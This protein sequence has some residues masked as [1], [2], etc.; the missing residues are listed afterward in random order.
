[1]KT[2]RSPQRLEQNGTPR[3][4]FAIHHGDCLDVLGKMLDDSIDSVVTDP[5]YGLSSEPDPVEVMRA[6]VNNESFLHRKKGFI[7]SPVKPRRSGR[8]YKGNFLCL[9]ARINV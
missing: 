8:G 6:W 5:P 3:V 1:M 2:Y 7:R 4:P 9:H